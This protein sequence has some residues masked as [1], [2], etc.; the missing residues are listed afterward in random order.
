[1]K[2]WLLELLACPIDHAF[3]LELTIFH[4]D[5]EE[6]TTDPILELITN[7]NNGSVIS[8]VANSPIQIEIK[9]DSVQIRDNLILKYQNLNDYLTNLLEKIEELPVVHDKSTWAGEQ[10]LNLILTQIKSSFQETISTWNENTDENTPEKVQQIIESLRPSLEFL[11]LF[12][13]QLEIEDGVIHCPQC[14]RWFPIFETIPQ[15]LPDD[16]R[17]AEQDAEFKEKWKDQF[18]F[19]T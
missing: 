14:N 2:L 3:P 18:D 17:N 12:K 8:D 13:Y 19:S 4:W 9:D 15:M 10:A 16:L 11:N 1:M 7:F 5:N 6:K